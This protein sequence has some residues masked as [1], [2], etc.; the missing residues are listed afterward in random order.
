MG[1]EQPSEQAPEQ[2]PAKTFDNKLS[3]VIR[4]LSR[5]KRKD[6]ENYV[7]NAVWNRLGDWSVKPVSQQYINNGG[8][9]Y[10]ID[11]YFPQLNIGIEIDEWYHS[12]QEGH[13]RQREFE[14][15]D[16][17]RQVRT[18]GPYEPIHIDTSKPDFEGQINDCVATL[19]ERIAK[20]KASGQFEE[21]TESISP[22]E[23]YRDKTRVTVNDDVGFWKISDICNTLF[24]TEY[25]MIQDSHF[26]PKGFRERYGE[27]YVLWCPKLA[28]DGKAVAQGWNNQI[29]DDGLTIRMFN[30]ER[31][32]GKGGASEQLV[33]FAR[34]RDP[35]TRI[36]EY[37]FFG[38]FKWTETTGGRARSERT[39]IF[40]RQSDELP[41]I[42]L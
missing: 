35:I 27:D 26:R 5:T 6:W 1:T 37:R 21:W 31:N 16:F 10:L 39:H 19:R 23:F 30:K 20:K 13:D 14:I 3:Y 18:D 12:R 9:R 40:T 29:S 28:I 38:V 32:I 25:K 34:V 36:S 24:G 15:I 22:Q 11:L 7:V 17:L 2:A 41:L 42:R 33:T 8:K 4:T